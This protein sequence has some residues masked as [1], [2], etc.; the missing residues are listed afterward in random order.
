MRQ[1]WV[2]LVQNTIEGR[3]TR[4]ALALSLVLAVSAV[5]GDSADAAAVHR[6]KAGRVHGPHAIV[7]A[8]QG[9]PPQG[10]FAVPG[11]S[12]DATRRWLDG[13]SSAW[14]QA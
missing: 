10:Q 14:T 3:S 9:A 8:G 12:D 2:T 11:W 6:S 13:A 1:A 5:A 7:P 4:A